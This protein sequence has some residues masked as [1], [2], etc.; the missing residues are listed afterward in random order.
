MCNF[1]I[2][3]V[4]HLSRGMLC[5]HFYEFGIK[6]RLGA[7]GLA[8]LPVMCETFFR[9]LKNFRLFFSPERLTRLFSLREDIKSF[10]N[11]KM[12]NLLTSDNFFHPYDT[13]AQP[14]SRMTTAIMND[15]G[16]SR[17]RTT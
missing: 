8:W 9:T 13:L 7:V 3:L 14:C 16:C 12:V 17:A 4:S 10:P 5:V 6:V 11:R 1:V 15:A 2:F